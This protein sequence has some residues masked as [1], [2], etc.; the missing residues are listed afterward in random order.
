[1]ENDD[2]PTAEL[3]LHIGGEL[4]ASTPFRVCIDDV[5]LSDPEFVRSRDVEVDPIES[6]VRR[7]D[8]AGLNNEE[9]RPAIEKTPQRRESF[10]Q[11]NILPARL[12]HHGCQLAIRERCHECEQASDDPHHKQPAGRT[13]LPGDD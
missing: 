6:A 13:D 2:D 9:E 12:R 8:C 11:V 7:R 1:M 4:A 10:A 3:A 5:V